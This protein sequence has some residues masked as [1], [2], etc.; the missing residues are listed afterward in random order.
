[1]RSGTVALVGRSNVGKSTLLNALLGEPLAIVSS[2]PQT[3]RDALLG[4][5]E[6][7]GAQIA[8]LDTPGV[9]KP[10]NELGRR[11]NHA[12]GEAARGADLVVMMVEVSGRTRGSLAPLTED[13]EILATLPK[14][15]PAV[16]LVNKIDQ[17]HD[18]SRLLPLLEAYAAARDWVAILPLTARSPD[19]AR[20]VIELLESALPEGPALYAP[21]TLTDRPSSFFAREYVREALLEC[22]GR[23]VPHAAAVSIDRYDDTGTAAVIQATLHVEKAGQRGIVVGQGG[24][25]IKEIGTRARKRIEALVGRKVHLELFV[26]VTP[27]WKDT[28]RQLAELGYE[29]GTK[30]AGAAPQRARKARTQSRRRR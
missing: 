23:E 6:R 15:V 8:L 29:A 4:V 10:H 14:G 5:V 30:S 22:T 24:S 3:T 21:D 26:R 9:H 13:L 18:K 11:M 25:M 20:R 27:A 7:P 19:G 17:V 28:P 1:M 2:K 16:L 12:S